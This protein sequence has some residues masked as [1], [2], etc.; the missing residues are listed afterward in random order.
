MIPHATAFIQIWFY[1]FFIKVLAKRK[2]P[3]CFQFQETHTPSFEYSKCANNILS[4][5][6]YRLIYSKP[7]S[8]SLC[9]RLFVCFVFIS[10]IYIFDYYEFA[11]V[12]Y[13]IR[14]IAHPP[15]VVVL[16]ASIFSLVVFIFIY[17]YVFV[18]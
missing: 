11:T 14:P 1:F 3:N 6:G 8:L 9:L 5:V 2:I 13:K 16:N 15:D 12:L 10:F 4:V 7:F 18:K 17:F